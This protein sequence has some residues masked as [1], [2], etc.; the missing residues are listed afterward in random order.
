MTDEEQEDDGLPGT[1]PDILRNVLFDVSFDRVFVDDYYPSLA[2]SDM[3]GMIDLALD[4]IKMSTED[5]RY[6]SKQSFNHL[7]AIFR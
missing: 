2:D 4:V 6:I 5:V 7:L 3:R 1:L